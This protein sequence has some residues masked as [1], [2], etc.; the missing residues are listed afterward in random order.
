M[1]EELKKPALSAFLFNVILTFLVAYFSVA[2][3]LFDSPKPPTN[4]ERI[5][6]IPEQRTQI[7]IGLVHLVAIFRISHRKKAVL[8]LPLNRVPLSPGPLQ[9]RHLVCFSLWLPRPAAGLSR[10]KG[11]L[12]L[13]SKSAATRKVPFRHLTIQLLIYQL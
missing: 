9:K 11:R 8:P 7:L 2:C 3:W 4:L 10:F 12:P 13:R 5:S 6:L 1:S